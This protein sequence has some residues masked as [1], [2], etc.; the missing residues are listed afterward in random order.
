LS[1]L[2]D[3]LSLLR[4]AV[5]A[6]GKVAL[7]FFEGTVRHWNKGP[8][9]PVSEADHAVDALLRE[10]L[11]GARPDYGWLS[12]E[13]EDDRSRLDRRQ[14]WIV[15]PIDGTRAF[16]RGRNQ[17][18][19]CAA[20]VSDGEPALAAV[21]NPATDELFEAV[22]GRGA[23]LNGQRIHIRQRDEL[24]G[25]HILGGRR[26]LENHAHGALPLGLTFETVN[27]IAYR[28]CLVACGRYDA[29][30]SLNGKS[31][32]DI[33]AADLVM[34]EAGGRITDRQDEP[35]R[36]NLPTARHGSVI[37]AAPGLHRQ[38]IDLVAD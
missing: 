23:W 15:D 4:E 30:I 5:Q 35:F 33:A 28:I 7:G 24:A 36:Y 20:L 22:R 8:D 31:D 6:A 29:C 9:D 34:T 26:A 3:D 37:A 11:G 18:A 38:I 2:D 1:R 19:V 32:W 25:A 21:L 27:S 14:V 17:F 16:I 12:E 13:T 10:R